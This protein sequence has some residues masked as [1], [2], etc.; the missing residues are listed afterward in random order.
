[1]TSDGPF[2]ISEFVIILQASTG[3]KAIIGQMQ[4]HNSA[5]SWASDEDTT[6]CNIGGIEALLRGW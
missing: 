2:Q 3:V 6:G 1:M 5:W 4:V